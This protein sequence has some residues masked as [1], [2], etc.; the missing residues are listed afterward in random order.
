MMEMGPVF[1]DFG[2]TSPAWLASLARDQVLWRDYLKP[3]CTSMAR[4]ATGLSGR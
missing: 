1:D 4:T 2:W 3:R